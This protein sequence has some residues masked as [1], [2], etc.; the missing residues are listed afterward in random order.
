MLFIIKRGKDKI[1]KKSENWRVY[2]D[3][4]LYHTLQIDNSYYRVSEI[5]F[6]CIKEIIPLLE[7]H[8]IFTTEFDI[9]TGTLSFWLNDNDYFLNKE[10]N[11]FSRLQ[12]RILADRI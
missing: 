9:D 5:S 12:K 8:G 7:T 1:S 4:N 10:D 2:K 3:S 11:S 6:E